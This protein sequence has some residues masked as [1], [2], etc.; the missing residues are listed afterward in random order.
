MDRTK[1]NKKS[2]GPKNY[3]KHLSYLNIAIEKYKFKFYPYHF[4][5]KD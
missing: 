5:N 2:C 1:K 3:F 4:K